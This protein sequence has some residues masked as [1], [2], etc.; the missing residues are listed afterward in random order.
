MVTDED[1]VEI[2][3]APVTRGW[4]L[5]AAIAGTF[6]H[7]IRLFYMPDDIAT[8]CLTWFVCLPALWWIGIFNWNLGQEYVYRA[9][10]TG[11]KTGYDS[12]KLFV[13]FWKVDL[14][15][16]FVAW[17][18]IAKLEYLLSTKSNRLIPVLKNADGEIILSLH[19][20]LGRSKKEQDKFLN[21]IQAK[22]DANRS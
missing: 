11:V 22:I 10:A 9:D 17:N 18:Q 2:H 5:F 13:P 6:G 7:L 15:R 16:K 8:E 3:A 19:L 4:L 20:L 12:S 1:A 21:F 14:K